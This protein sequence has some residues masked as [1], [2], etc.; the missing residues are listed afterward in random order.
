[1][2]FHQNKYDRQLRLWEAAGQSKIENASCCLLYVNN[3]GCEC[4]KNLI[5][6]GIGKICILDDRL[7]DKSVDAPNFFLDEEDH[8]KSKVE[9]LAENLSR[10]NPD[11]CI[12]SKKAN[13]LDIISSDI[14]FFHSFNVV[15]LADM[16]PKIQLI[17]LTNYLW[18]KQIAFLQL[19]SIG[20]NGSIRVCLPD[21]T[22]LQTQ[23]DA[24]LDLRLN[25]PWAELKEYSKQLFERES[26]DRHGDIPF[27]A[28]LVHGC[29]QLETGN[30]GNPSSQRKDIL[31]NWIKTQ[32]LYADEENFEEALS[33]CWRP[34]QST[35]IS[36]ALKTIFDDINCQNLNEQSSS[37]W[38]I[39]NAICKF[40]ECYHCIPVSGILP[41]MKAGS[42]E[43]VSLQRVY[44]QKAK[45]D[46]L[47]VKNYVQK[48]LKL[49]SRPIDSITDDEIFQFC[50]NASQAR[51]IKYRKIEE[52]LNSPLLTDL[53]SDNESLV[54]W[55]F[56]FR[57]FDI[58]KERYNSSPDASLTSS[59]HKY[60]EIAC[61]FMKS[62]GQSPTQS[63]CNACREI[64]RSAGAE[65]HSVSAF[66][67]AIAAQEA[68]KFLTR[69]YIPLNNTCLVDA[70]HARTESFS[71]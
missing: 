38:I 66:I 49:L 23:N 28:I 51:Y 30:K 39:M 44:Q 6:P 31:R 54:P 33:N 55:Y 12:E 65:I 68:I 19:R 42:S 14:D 58:Y 26:K 10:L 17:K 64:S 4:L 22:I 67:G 61:E 13:P 7:V 71:F 41:D 57:C 46:A 3:V 59:I 16:L 25:M 63:V 32:M 62:L 27:V 5:L 45:E 47:K 36:S 53:A 9:C 60:E 70:A 37:F 1:M 8:N 56:A 21:C 24:S 34:F 48:N 69:Q 18:N 35:N 15:I 43:F 52:E 40:V 2:S 50:K 20:F 29:S 11:V